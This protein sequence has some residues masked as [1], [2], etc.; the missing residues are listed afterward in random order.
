MI[1]RETVHSATELEKAI[2][3]WLANWN[4]APAPF[5]WKASVGVILGKVSRCKELTGTGG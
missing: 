4:G 5:V 2:Y 1:R 3:N